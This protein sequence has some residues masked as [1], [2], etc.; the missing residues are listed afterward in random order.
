MGQSD[1]CPIDHGNYFP[2]H[3]VLRSEQ[4]LM[5]VSFGQ[6]THTGT[7]IY[8][9]RIDHITSVPM[10]KEKTHKNIYSSI[11]FHARPFK[12]AANYVPPGLKELFR[13]K[14]I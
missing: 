8:T 11:P 3:L 13:R 5:L 14:F 7:H 12:R 4:S 1:T 6:T 10:R 9:S 2:R